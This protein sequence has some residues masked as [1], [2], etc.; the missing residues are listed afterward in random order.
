MSTDMFSPPP[1]LDG[2]VTPPIPAELIEP[3]TTV[4]GGG[5]AVATPPGFADWAAK[6]MAATAPAVEKKAVEYG[7]NSLAR[8]GYRY[9]SAQSRRVT[10]AEAL[11]LGAS[12][13][14][15]EKADRMEDALL[16]G[17]SPSDDT[18][19]DSIVYGLMILFIR[20][21]GRWV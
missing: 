19:A 3:H 18:L 20:Q 11:E 9:A 21:N 16:R 6:W 7:S 5:A 1:A 4:Y 2:N 8:K 10:E 13:Y 14:L 12:Q 15:V 17:L